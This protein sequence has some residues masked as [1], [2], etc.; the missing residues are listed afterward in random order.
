MSE[1]KT[2]TIND[3]LEN[4]HIIEDIIRQLSW[5]QIWQPMEEGDPID[6]RFPGIK[7]QF[8]W[9]LTDRLYVIGKSVPRKLFDNDGT[10]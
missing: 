6:K 4:V 2:F 1:W 3:E 9:E 8:L 7:G 10:A 5:S